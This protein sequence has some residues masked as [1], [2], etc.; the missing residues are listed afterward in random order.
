MEYLSLCKHFSEIT[1][2]ELY[3]IMELRVRVFM[4]EQNCD[5]SELDGKDLQCY[6]LSFYKAE[7]LIA[8]ARLLAPGMSY[9]QMSIGRVLVHPEYRGQGLGIVLMQAAIIQ[10]RQLFGT[11]AIKI[12][13]QL[14][15]EQFYQNL[16]FTTISDVYTEAGIKHIKMILPEV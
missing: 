10:C 6:H 11:G 9:Q 3:Q 14:Y 16:G 4:I 5:E 12:S 13:A 1:T 2:V 8:Y 15:L 7:T